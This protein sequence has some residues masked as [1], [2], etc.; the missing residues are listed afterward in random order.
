MNAIAMPHEIDLLL[1]QDLATFLHRS[2]LQLNPNLPL[3][4]NWHLDLLAD[5]LTQVYEGR[6]KRLIIN[7]PPR[8]LKS[9]LASVAFPAWV[10]G[11]RPNS[12]LICVSYGQELALKMARDSQSLMLTPWYQRAFPTRLSARSATADFETLEKGGRL[13]TSVGGVLTGRGGD[14]LIIDDPV[15]PDE[16]VS[17][18]Q[19]NSANAWYDQSLY[20]RLNDKREGAIILIMQ[21]LHL[22]DMVGHVRAKEDWEVVSLPAI[23]QDHEEWTYRT[24]RGITTKVRES[25]ELLH[26]GREGRAQLD[27][28]LQNMGSYAFSAQYLQDPV[29]MGGALVKTEWLH[30]YE[31]HECPE[32]FDR[33]VQSWD[34]ASKATEAADYSVCTTW[35]IKGKRTYL[36]HVLRKRM[37]YPELKRTVVQQKEAWKATDIL[38]ED[39]ASGIQLIQ[40]LKSEGLAG[41]RGAAAESDKYSRM[42]AQT[43]QFE[44][45]FVRIPKQAP[46]LEAYIHELTSFPASKYDDQVD[47]TSQALAW[48]AKEGQ[49]PGIIGFYEGELASRWHCS[50]EEVQERLRK[51]RERFNFV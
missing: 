50:V 11:N 48:I 17:E 33:I 30:P 5:R 14:I 31:E 28:A 21:R 23:A 46:W 43:P 22:D 29:P 18:A 38:I 1:R 44:N 16:A 6:L 2:F 34:T 45:G 19:R 42:N 25:G 7:V 9:I 8:S 15:K 39:K 35:G 20:S 27:A 32:R 47:S 4:W 13:A 36:R 12:R 51:E 40:E 41:F 37:D 3:V 24:P 49:V 26:P 10:L